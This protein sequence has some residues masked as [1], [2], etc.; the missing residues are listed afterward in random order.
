MVIPSI[1]AVL[2]L[3]I[4]SWVED[5]KIRRFCAPQDLAHL[6]PNLQMIGSRSCA[7]GVTIASLALRKNGSVL[8]T[9]VALRETRESVESID[10]ERAPER[11]A[12]AESVLWL[13]PVNEVAEIPRPVGAGVWPVAT[14]VDLA[15]RGPLLSHETNL[16]L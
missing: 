14:K 4:G 10:V 16:T 9:T 5:S 1:L 15:R 7:A 12:Q 3:I 2:R 6:K 13:E 11:I 8:M